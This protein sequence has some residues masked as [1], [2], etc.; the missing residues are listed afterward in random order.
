MRTILLLLAIFC[1]QAQSQLVL[2]S[3][4]R[5]IDLRDA[6]E[7]IRSLV[8]VRNDGPSQEVLPK[9]NRVSLK[10]SFHKIK[11]LL[12]SFL[13]LTFAVFFRFQSEMIVAIPEAKRFNVSFVKVCACVRAYRGVYACMRMRC[14]RVCGLCDAYI[15]CFLSLV[16]GD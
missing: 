3:V 16:S 11:A 13:C 14:V 12:S 7:R 6:A 10:L 9:R 2:E 1:L 4:E 15:S 8:V 5:Q